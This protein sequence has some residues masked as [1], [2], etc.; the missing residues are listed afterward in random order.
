MKYWI[1]LFIAIIC[2]VVGTSAMK[3]AD[4]FTRL[5]PSLVVTA[6]YVASF[7]FL[8][9]TLRVIPL[10]IAY[11]IWCGL[12]IVLVALA[13]WLYYG[14]ELDGPALFGLGLILAGLFVINI[15]SK[16]AQN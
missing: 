16:S 11:A 8:S 2:E 13:G 4:G 3:A 7:Y 12:G 10:G 6:G 14:Q 9:L 5:W 15:F 1:Y